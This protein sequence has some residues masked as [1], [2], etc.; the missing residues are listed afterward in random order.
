MIDVTLLWYLFSFINLTLFF[1]NW[2]FVAKA[3]SYRLCF[4]IAINSAVIGS[5]VWVEGDN[6]YYSRDS[7]QFGPVPYSLLEGKVFC[8]VTTFLSLAH[9]MLN[10]DAFNCTVLVPAKKQKEGI[11]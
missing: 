8:K 6:I 4:V 10:F 9:L 5:H 7:R 11:I 3:Y 1:W 2:L